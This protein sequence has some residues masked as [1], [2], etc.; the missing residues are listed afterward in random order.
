M[1]GEPIIGKNIKNIRRL[2]SG[3]I[4][5]DCY[6]FNSL[7]PNDAVWDG[8]IYS[9]ILFFYLFINFFFLGSW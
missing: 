9:Q 6:L 3:F 5:L 1:W 7:P 2:I 8:Q 4:F